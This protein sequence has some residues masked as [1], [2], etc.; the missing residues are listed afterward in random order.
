[1]TPGVEGRRVVF[2]R[3]L[4]PGES[5]ELLLKVP[6]I[7]LDSPPDL[8]A[9]DGLQ[10]DRC[11]RVTADFWRTMTRQGAQLACPEPHLTALHA[12]HLSH[13][14]ITDSPMPEGGGLVNTSVGTSTYGNFANEACMVIHELDQRGLHEEA[15]RRI[16]VWIKYQ[17]TAPQP[18][19]F[20]DYDGMYFGAGGF[21][22]GDYNQ[23]HGWVLWCIGMHYFLTG[24]AEWLDRI[25]P[26]L[27][28]GCDW[29]FRQRRN[30]MGVL[31]HSRGWEHGF[32]PAGSLEDVT[33]FHYWLSTN[34]L[35]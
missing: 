4:Q 30:T 22:S 24:D 12:S 18:G 6:F 31:P 32:L 33:D 26:S 1:M 21:E 34:A 9:L 14:S 17:G 23:H 8:A 15:R 19:K 29:V 5:C 25:A 7:A 13:V 20:T 35:T 3:H 16:E 11:Y 27:I 10:F 2:R 28:A